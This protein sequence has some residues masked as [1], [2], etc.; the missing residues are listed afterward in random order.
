MAKRYFD[1]S[2]KIKPGVISE[3]LREAAGIHRDK[4]PIWIYRMRV[5]GYP[6][7]YLK[8]AQVST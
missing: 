1:N 5:L 3:E 6:P 7:G 4:L 8:Q 2:S